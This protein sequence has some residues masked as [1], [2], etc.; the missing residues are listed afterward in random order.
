MKCTLLGSS[1]SIFDK[2]CKALNVI[3]GSV[4]SNFNGI[5]SQISNIFSIP[6]IRTEMRD[7]HQ[8]MGYCPQ[9]DAIDELLTG[10]EHLEFYARLRG[11]PEDEVTM[12]IISSF[13]SFCPCTFKKVSFHP[14]L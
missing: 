14:W 13:C 10:K 1:Y 4:S 12:V 3:F 6:S 8:N 11:V 9:F 5:H 2:F 7:V